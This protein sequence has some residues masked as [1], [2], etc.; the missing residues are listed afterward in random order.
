M[1]VSLVTRDSRKSKP[2]G[3]TKTLSLELMADQ[4][5]GLG[6]GHEALVESPPRWFR[7][8]SLE[9]R[10]PRLEAFVVIILVQSLQ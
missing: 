9:T 5:R 10:E 3:A 6:A 4:G 2:Q 7:V 8:V 1:V